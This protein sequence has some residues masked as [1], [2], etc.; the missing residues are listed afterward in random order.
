MDHPWKASEVFDVQDYLHFFRGEL[1]EAK[2][3]KD[4]EVLLEVGHFPAGAKIL[5]LACGHGRISTLLAKQGFHV[6]GIDISTD[7][8]LL[9][10]ETARDQNLQISYAQGDVRE[11]KHRGF[12][13][14]IS[15]FTSFGY[16]EDDDN[17]TI[18]DNVYAAL[19]PGGVFILDI[20]N[21]DAVMRDFSSLAV[22]EQEDG[23][24]LRRR[25]FDIATG[26]AYNDSTV[27]RAN[28][29]RD[30]RYYTRLFTFTEIKEWLHQSGFISVDAFNHNARPLETFSTRM[31][32]AAKK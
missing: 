7:F 23:L 12:D 4:M 10:E 19:K 32:I 13:A 11:L 27:F 30:F 5:D 26:R 14:A 22:L 16:Y 8:L 2:S 24:L 18:L 25:S 1:S 9:A 6:T 15:W 20:P 29:R 17:R 21:R 31:L 28:H 3:Q